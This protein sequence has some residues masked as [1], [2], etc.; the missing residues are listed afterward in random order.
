M[1]TN[2][3]NFK[4]NQEKLA[5]EKE[6]ANLDRKVDF[7][8]LG[9]SKDELME[10]IRHNQAEEYLK[11]KEV[12]ASDR[13]G[14]MS[15]L[16]SIFRGLGLGGALGGLAAAVN[17]E[18]YHNKLTV[19][20]DQATKLPFSEKAGNPH[21]WD[22]A[23]F[24]APLTYLKFDMHVKFTNSGIVHVRYVPT[25]SVNDQEIQSSE[26][27]NNVR[28]LFSVVRAA[29]SGAVNQ[30][31]QSDL[32]QFTLASSSVF[33]VLRCVVRPFNYIAAKRK[34]M[35][36]FSAWDE[37]M[38]TV[39]TG[40]SA[41]AR[42]I[43]NEKPEYIQAINSAIRAANAQSLP[44][45][46]DLTKRRSLLNGRIFTH[47]KDRDEYYLF[48]PTCYYVY[49]E[50]NAKLISKQ[51]NI[52]SVF[53]SPDNVKQVLNEMLQPLVNGTATAI[54]AGDMKK[55]FPRQV[56]IIRELPYALKGDIYSEDEHI[57][58]AL[59]N[60]NL[61]EGFDGYGSK[62]DIK[63]G[64]NALLDTYIYQG[65]LTTRSDGATIAVL[66]ND[67]EHT[68]TTE[69]MTY[70]QNTPTAEDYKNLLDVKVD[71]P[72]KYDIMAG[73]RFKT[74]FRNVY[75][76][77]SGIYKV[78]T[79]I[80]QWGT[81]IIVGCEI[82]YFQIQAEFDNNTPHKIGLRGV[83]AHGFM[84]LDGAGTYEGQLYGRFHYLPMK[85][86][87]FVADLVNTNFATFKDFAH[88]R[89]NAITLTDK[90]LMNLNN[91]SFG[92]LVSITQSKDTEVE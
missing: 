30:Y 14:F 59:R 23:G 50:A 60:A 73:T 1:T 61:M 5:V 66:G 72:V 69:E 75:A 40:T 92:S 56:Q 36:A 82:T 81:E 54:M 33:E 53:A 31:D 13:N 51:F 63:Q 49:D 20:Y 39:M 26:L 16:G 62:F 83:N 12:N 45:G 6:I 19:A 79:Q 91:A 18:S 24:V 38:L 77:D 8:K 87:Q 80:Y 2:A 89:Y 15:G 10:K 64:I 42:R 76:E 35:N 22:A 65:T 74:S 86:K 11:E 68:Y 4:N 85:F 47:S 71:D 70:F 48:T 3:V 78:G 21:Y 46:F 52:A 88:G 41:N 67:T 29:N 32:M 44:I 57:L 7:S 28:L 25:I 84:P 90:Q 43:I 17:D 27:Q 34:N 37:T 55:A 58:E 9:I